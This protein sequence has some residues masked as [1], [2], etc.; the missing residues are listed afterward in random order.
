MALIE[1]IGLLCSEDPAGEKRAE[2]FCE[3]LM[4]SVRRST[5]TLGQ[6][7]MLE[8]FEEFGVKAEHLH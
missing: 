6:Q 3:R 8:L 2:E 7:K 4:A 1:Q 5:A